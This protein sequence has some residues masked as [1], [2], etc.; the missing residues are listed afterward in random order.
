MPG[1]RTGLRT[2]KVQTKNG[3]NSNKPWVHS[4]CWEPLGVSA[5]VPPLMPL[6]AGGGWFPSIEIK[7]L[8]KD[9]SRRPQIL[10]EP[11]CGF[12]PPVSDITLH[13]PHHF[14]HH[15]KQLPPPAPYALVT[16]SCLNY[17]RHSV[18]FD[19][20]LPI[21]HTAQPLATTILLC[22]Y[23]FESFRFHI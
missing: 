5:R 4:P 13:H 6:G 20:H 18:P 11:V 7:E 22:F 9:V 10:L 3:W 17:Y 12:G 23:E 8:L 16:V 19:Q 1:A 14:C 15:F 2:R 21:F